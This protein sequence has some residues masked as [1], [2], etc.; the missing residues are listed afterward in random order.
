MP[1]SSFMVVKS[2]TNM[3][4]WYWWNLFESSPLS[5]LLLVIL[6][7]S[8]PSEADAQTANSPPKLNLQY[9]LNIDRPSE[10]L[11]EVTIQITGNTENQLKVALPAWSP[12]RYVIF[13]F[14]KNVQDFEASTLAPPVKP[15][16]WHKLDKQTWQIECAGVS[17]LEIH[18]NIFGNDLSGTFSQLDASHANYNGG[19]VFMYLVDHKQDPLEL[20]LKYPSE[21]QIISGATTST[22]QTQCHF[23]NYDLLVDTPTEIGMLDIGSFTLAER[24]YRVAVHNLNNSYDKT[25]LINALQ[26][27][28]EIETA[29]WGTPDFEHYTFLIHL[30]PISIETDGM[31]HLNSTQ[32]IENNVDDAIVTAAHEFFHLWNVKRL[33]PK[34]LGPWDYSHEVYTQSLWIS[35]GL[36]NYYGNLCLTRAGITSPQEYYQTLSDQITYVQ[37][38]NGRQTMSLEQASFDTWLFLAAPRTQLTNQENTTIS[39]YAKGELVGMMLDLEIRACTN[40]SKSLDD[41]FRYM[42]QHYYLD[43]IAPTYYLKGTGFDDNDFLQAVNKITASDFRPFFQDYISGTKELNYNLSLKAAGLTLLLHN[44]SYTIKELPNAT[45]AEI[46]LRNSWLNR[47][48]RTARVNH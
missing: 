45:K 15:L 35:E 11:F 18:Y 8:Y 9:T 36:T 24:K 2:L 39:Y 48:T 43:S 40:N 14:A 12:G 5:L 21:W 44:G 20:L 10:H 31:E 30:V 34:E 13:D 16:K 32:I 46:N 41:V 27:I 47:T 1:C 3:K 42:Y 17:S 26:H 19:S 28:V 29:I 22:T 6:V 33:R 25:K 38:R 7:L 37:K 23:D 4:R